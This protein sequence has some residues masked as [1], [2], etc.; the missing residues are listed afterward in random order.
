MHSIA[1]LGWRDGCSSLPSAYTWANSSCGP[2]KGTLWVAASSFPKWERANFPHHLWPA[3]GSGQ[4]T[5]CLYLGLWEGEDEQVREL[6]L[7]QC[8]AACASAVADS[9][10]VLSVRISVSEDKDSSGCFPP[11]CN[12]PE[13]TKVISHQKLWG[14]CKV[15]LVSA[16][17]LKDIWTLHEAQCSIRHAECHAEP[18]KA[19]CCKDRGTS[20]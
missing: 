15:S 6:L 13:S 4:G 7:E 20:L 14:L 12:Q 1:E 10:C 19:H 9:L 11:P 17:L 5:C 16:Q 18:S 2:A 8:A 3:D